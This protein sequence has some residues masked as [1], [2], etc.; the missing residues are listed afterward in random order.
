MRQTVMR[1]IGRVVFR[2]QS[3]IARTRVESALDRELR[4]HLEQQIQENVANGMAPR[5]AYHSAQRSI[6][7]L[8][9]VKDECRDSL[10]FRFTDQVH[11]DVASTLRSMGRNP[12]LVAAIVLS[13]ALGIGINSV[14]FAVLDRLMLAPLPVRDPQE[15]VSA[16]PIAIDSSGA[17]VDT[18]MRFSYSAF[19]AFRRTLPTTGAIAA[20][21]RVARMYR[22][23]DGQSE[24]AATSVQLVSGE[25]FSLLGIAAARG[26]LLGPA[27]NRTVGGHPV[28]VMSHAIWTNAFGADP[29]VV[30]RGLAINGAPFI[31]VGVAPPGFSGVWLESPVD[32]WLP[33]VM[34]H[35]VRYH[36]DYSN[37]DAKPL[38]PWVPQET[39]RWLDIVI[40][41]PPSAAAVV[42]AALAAEYRQVL[43]REAEHIAEP[44]DRGLLVQQ[45]L[46]VEPFAQG[47]S[48]LRARFGS[49]LF[50][51]FGMAA[52][53]LVIACANA[54]NLL[55]AR[56]TVRQREMA[57]KLSIG[58]SRR[59]LVVQLLTESAVL[60]VLATAVA[61]QFTE[62]AGNLLVRHALGASAAG[63]VPVTIDIGARLLLFAIAA[64]TVT[65]LFFGLAPSFQ[66]TR[67]TLGEALR[68]SARGFTARPRLQRLLVAVQVALSFVLVVAAGLFI[69]TFQ[70]YAQLNLGFSQEHLLSVVI[71]PMAA[72]YA[73]ERLPVLSNSLISAVEAIPGVESASTAMCALV[74]G[75]R[76]IG[77]LSIE[78]SQQ[79][80]DE[81]AQ[82]QVN[83]VSVNYFATTG[84]RLVEGRDFD[85]HDHERAPKVAVVNRAMARRF[86]GAESPLGRRIGFGTTDTEI[87]GVVED[88][89]VN[90]VQEPAPSMVYYPMT[91]GADPQAVEVRAL[92][93]P[94]TIITD[95]RTAIG[96]VAPDVPVVQITLMSDRV[97]RGLNQE[98]LVAALA[99]IFGALALVLACIGLFGVM[100]YSVSRRTAELGIRMALGA[101]RSRV[102]TMVFRE[103][104]AV[105][106]LG[107]AVGVVILLTASHALSA[108]LFGVNVGDPVTLAGAMAILAGV[109]LA[110]TAIPAWRASRVEQ[111][112]ALRSE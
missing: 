13:L 50:V 96:R 89:R 110:A 60:A 9:H 8:A 39:L 61:L 102:L 85:T 32:L 112:I 105:V 33:V 56:A 70:N 64:T 41:R 98:R 59:R 24:L 86:F 101:S 90:R 77:G 17:A 3:V 72:G 46:L 16:K 20:M 62:W 83:R 31:I 12:G 55:L 47:F 29:N 30:G 95:V 74:A 37:M 87:V 15:L 100:S 4:F 6:G 19:E 34:Q 82:I 78:R 99:S 69:R 84:T 1:T 14:I 52:L 97:A 103:S 73:P 21:S 43:R 88:A 2:M 81:R 106:A 27:D 51:L 26:R 23:H 44:N 11:R 48:N 22:R 45:R 67:V 58:A 18:P 7:S 49:P 53:I 42:S 109:A 80:P 10:G 63:S 57:V 79:R 68:L 40:R 104:L 75:C 93:D 76:S 38:D 36:Q 35:D 5:E 91:Q 25:F 28:A 66:A 94:R 107:L 111:V 92:G 71:N 65:V 108:L 54:A